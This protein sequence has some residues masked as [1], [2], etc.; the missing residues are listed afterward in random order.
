SANSMSSRIYSRVDAEPAEPMVWPQVDGPVTFA[1]GTGKPGDSPQARRE[2]LER[3]MERRVQ[4]ARAAG[5]Q[6]GLASAKTAAAAELKALHERVAQTIAEL[7]ALRPRLRRQAEA[8][9]VKLSLAIA[10]RILHRELMVD[11]EAMRGLIQAALEKLQ[12]Q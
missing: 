3:E 2:E 7:A 1:A 8:D 11:S 10:R 12:S 4:E 9:L 6:D 5:F